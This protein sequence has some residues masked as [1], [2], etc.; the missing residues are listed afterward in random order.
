MLL[1]LSV[2]GVLL[3]FILFFRNFKRNIPSRFL[4]GF[5]FLI[6]FYSLG[7]YI[8]IFSKSVTL[9]SV[10]LT[11]FNFLFYLTG[12]MLFLYIRCIMNES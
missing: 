10:F 5:M 12:P 4:A 9:V 7:Q 8:L 1:A 3:S 2:L 11:H 6:S